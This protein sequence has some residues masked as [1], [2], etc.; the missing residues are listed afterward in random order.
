MASGNTAPDGALEPSIRFPDPINLSHIGRLAGVGRA[1][2]ANWR[3]HADDFPA[4]VGGTDRSPEFGLDEV[5]AWL[6]RNNK[7]STATARLCQE[8]SE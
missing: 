4:P 5:C 2:V 6:L 8:G 7:I 1:A 3:R